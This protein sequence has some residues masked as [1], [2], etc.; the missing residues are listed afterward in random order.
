MKLHVDPAILNSS[1]SVC[2]PNVINSLHKRYDRKALQVLLREKRFTGDA[3]R[4][5]ERFLADSSDE[6]SDE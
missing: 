3:L 6:D 1:V 2:D 4:T 5:V